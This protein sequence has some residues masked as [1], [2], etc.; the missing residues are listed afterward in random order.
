MNPPVPPTASNLTWNFNNNSAPSV[1][2]F[3]TYT[4][5]AGGHNKF[6]GNVSQNSMK[7][8][9]L[10]DNNMNTPSSWENCTDGET[11]IF[12]FLTYSVLTITFN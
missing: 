4:C 2:E 3:V 9:C 1:G 7:I 8:E 6:I 5:S 10:V 11:S 12:H